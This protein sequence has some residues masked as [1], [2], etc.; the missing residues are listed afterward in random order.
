V[1]LDRDPAAR[2]RLGDELARPIASRPTGCWS[3]QYAGANE[4]E[5]SATRC[6]PSC[7]VRMST[8]TPV[9]VAG[10]PGLRSA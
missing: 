1:A 9:T 7:A 6:W 4:F 10:E 8:S 2:V 3:A 5:D